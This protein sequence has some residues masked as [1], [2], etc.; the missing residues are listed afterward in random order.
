[1]NDGNRKRMNVLGR[2]FGLN[3]ILSTLPYGLFILVQGFLLKRAILL[4]A[5]S[6]L[7][8]LDTFRAL[9]GD[10][11][12]FGIFCLLLAIG[13]SASRKALRS[14]LIGVFSVVMFVSGI[15]QIANFYY[16]EGTGAALSREVLKYWFQNRGENQSLLVSEARPGRLVVLGLQV[17]VLLLT[18]LVPRLK[19]IRGWLAR[20]HEVHGKRILA[21][22]LVAG[23]FLE[24]YSFVP[25]LTDVHPALEP[26]A[27]SE[28]FSGSPA[29]EGKLP[30]GFVISAADRMDGRIELE[31][32]PAVPARNVVLIIFESMNWKNSDV[33]IPAKGTTPFLADLARRGAVIDR[34]YTVVPHTT[35]ALVPILC[36]FY[37]YL[38]PDVKEAIPGILPERGLAHILRKEGYATAFF[39]T[40]NNY[41]SRN[42]VVANMGFET[43][44]GVFDM[45]TEG[46]SDTNYFGKEERM[47]LA[48]S[49]DWAEAQGGRPFFLTYLTL[50]THHN[51]ETPPTWPLI[52]FKVGN[53]L[54]NQYLNAV[55][56]TDEFIKEV[57]A[58]FESRGLTKDKLFIIVGDHGEAFNEHGAKGHNMTMYEEGIRPLGLLYSPGLIAA[59]SRIMGYRSIL[60]IVPT[61]CDFL[62]LRVKDGR[63]I[64]ESMFQ[65]VPADRTLYFSAWARGWGMAVRRGP[66]KTIHWPMKRKF[67]VFDNDRDPKDE[68][69]RLGQGASSSI[70]PVSD[71]EEMNRWADTVNA[72]Y[73]EWEK[74]V[75]EV[76]SA[77][78]PPMKNEIRGT[79]GRL[80]SLVGY[81]AY[82]G[83]TYRERSVWIKLALRAEARILRPLVLIVRL[84]HRSG[85]AREWTVRVPA[86]DRYDR[87]K[88]G[89][90][91][92]A[93]TFINIPP[94]WPAGESALLASVLDKRNRKP[95]DLMGAESAPE[96]LGP[97]IRLCAFTV[98]E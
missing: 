89:R 27:P 68:Q 35:K 96:P 25:P 22:Y 2:F 9:R 81:E 95:L 52:D 32:D 53:E 90:Y 37:P 86:L 73:R 6:L 94:D 43:F 47:M 98:L 80:V 23:I 45:P 77:T 1:M 51:Y 8:E 31:K 4:K 50:C 40:A 79:F 55:R 17:F 28:G 15:Y 72:Q 70:S 84:A 41:E 74:A 18:L 62:G 13:I 11:I 83:A 97:G 5:E 34:I 21:A 61:V 39:Q 91:F 67:E 92:T 66:L 46:F 49:L 63:F 16:Y 58:G 69:K 87:L 24:A 30:E 14:I 42:Q 57:M 85:K 93:E 26:W 59:G 36:G 38:E 10:L 33:Y 44:K 7:S 75:K 71:A 54:E 60:D 78:P 56:Y 19:G 88:P 65:T 29:G 20:T 3:G 82:P 48:P 12:F 64:G 76:S